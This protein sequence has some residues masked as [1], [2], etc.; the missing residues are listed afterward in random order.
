MKWLRKFEE[1]MINIDSNKLFIFA[2]ILVVLTLMAFCV[3]VAIIV[4]KLA[5]S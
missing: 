1:K 3:G 4:T 2:C 5:T